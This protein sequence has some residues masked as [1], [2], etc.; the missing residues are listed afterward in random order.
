MVDFVKLKAA[1]SDSGMTMIAISSKSGILRETL[2]NKLSG[3]GE[4]TVSEIEGLSRTLHL[5]V[6]QRN[7]IFF[8]KE[9]V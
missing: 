8:A 5:S 9:V 1:I 4:F 3:K 7:E 6:G 2:Y